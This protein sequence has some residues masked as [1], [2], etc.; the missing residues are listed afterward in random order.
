M[1]YLLLAAAAAVLVGYVVGRVRPALR[2]A[3]W[4]AWKA[5]GTRKGACWR[6][7]WLVLQAE[8]LLWIACHPIQT[9]D[10]WRHRNDPPPPRSPAI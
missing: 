9:R 1:R 10:A 2:L 4:A 7:A 5:Y 8:A 6:I 3:N